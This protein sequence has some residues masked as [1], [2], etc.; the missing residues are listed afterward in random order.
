ML[1]LMVFWFFIDNPVYYQ[2]QRKP[3]VVRSFWSAVMSG[4]RWARAVAAISRSV[5]SPWAT[6]PLSANAAMAGV[7]GRMFRPSDST[8]SSM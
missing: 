8:M 2:M 1:Y 6:I 7:S 3:G 4:T 5:G